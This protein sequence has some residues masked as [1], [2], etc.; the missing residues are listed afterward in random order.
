MSQKE[1]FVVPISAVQ[2]IDGVDYVYYVDEQDGKEVAKLQTVTLGEVSGS[3][4]EVCGIQSG[5]KIINDGIK[6]I[7]ENQEVSVIGE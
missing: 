6:N 4:I 1:V 2:N 5:M 7:T 3:G